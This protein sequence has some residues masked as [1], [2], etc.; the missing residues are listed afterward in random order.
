MRATCPECGAQ[1]HVSAFFV[2]D[3]GKRL[4]ALAAEM[5]PELGRAVTGYLGLFK[6]VKTALRLARA[7]KLVQEL[8]ALVATGDVCKDE[9]NGVRRPASPSIWAAGIETMLAQRASLS[10]PLD[11]HNYLRAV[12]FGLA[13]KADAATERQK[14]AGARVGKHLDSL[15]VKSV[16]SGG[17]SP[18]ENTLRWIKQM[19]GMGGEYTAEWAD[20]ER[21]KAREKYGSKA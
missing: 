9:R 12:V 1:A 21:A 20:A 19:E 13:D 7:V 3:D 16:A 4:F 2:E 18:L 11:N 15:S 5:Q 6:P 14:E 8:V 17:E 10:L